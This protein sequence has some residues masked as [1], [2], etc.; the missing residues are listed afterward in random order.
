MSASRILDGPPPEHAYKRKV[1]L[2][3]ELRD[4]WQSRGLIRTLTERDLRVRYKQAVLGFL[5]AILSPFVLMVVFSVFFQRV[6]KVDTN[7]APYPL[8]AYLG[9]IPWGFFSSAVAGGGTSILS[10]T[11]LLNKV[12][13]PRE[14]FPIAAVGVTVADTAVSLLM[15]AVI[16]AIYTVAPPL[17]AFL[18]MIPLL[19][20]LVAFT[21]GIT[22]LVAAT[23]VYFRD[24]RQAIPLI[25]QLGL[26]A[27]PV[28]Y[29]M[30]FIPH[31]FWIA[32][33]V[34]NPLAPVI[35]GIRGA[36]LFH[37]SPDLT[38]LIPAAIAATVWLVVGYV[39]FKKLETRFADVA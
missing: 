10:N 38:L 20:V 4:V 9:L 19:L 7:G 33:A 23:I 6:A 31:R 2:G 36:F 1:R 16:F 30:E 27:T 12:Y 18:W 32:Y 14:V 24:L 35:E 8:F 37:R 39:A 26:F 17:W 28:A 29:G 15:V 5:W 11:A 34:L 22:L 13:C 3:L 25:L 21:L